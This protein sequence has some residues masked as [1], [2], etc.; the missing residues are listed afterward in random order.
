[1]LYF[2]PGSAGK[3]RF[4]LPRTVALMEINAGEISYRFVPLE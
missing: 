3:K 4:D 2:N 1:M